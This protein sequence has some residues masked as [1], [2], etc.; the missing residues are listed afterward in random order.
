MIAEAEQLQGTDPSLAAQLDLVAHHMDPTADVTSVTSELLDTA[1]IPLSNPL[2]GPTKPIHSVKFSP[3]GHIL[4][5]SSEDGT[6]RLWNVTDPAHA[7][8]IG[9]PLTKPTWGGVLT[10]AFSPDGHVLA[11]VGADSTVRLWNVTDPAHATQIGQ[12]LTGPASGLHSV[13]FSPDGHALAAGSYDGTIRLWNVTDPAH[14]TQ[15]GQPLTGPASDVNSVAFSPDGH[16]LAAGSGTARSGCGTS[17]TPPTPPGS[18]SPLPASPTPSGRWC[19]ARTGI[20]WPPAA[21]T[22]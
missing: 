7:T 11:A 5:A 20:P 12:P 21:R 1:N 6:I 18:G 2:T 13:A 4:A 9:Q 15:I 19:S 8:Q 17:P 14:A 10:V 3:D 22:A 16:A